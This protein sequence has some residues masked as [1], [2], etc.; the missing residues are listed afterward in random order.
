LAAFVST[1]LNIQT[2]VSSRKLLQD[3]I[4]QLVTAGL[5]ENIAYMLHQWKKSGSL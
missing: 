2:G 1:L 3:C 4:H 5:N